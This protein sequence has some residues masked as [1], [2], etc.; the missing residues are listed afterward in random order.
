MMGLQSFKL[1]N[2]W[3]YIAYCLLV[4]LVNCHTRRGPHSLLLLLKSKNSIELVRHPF[5]DKFAKINSK[6][7]KIHDE[8][9]DGEFYERKTNF[10][11]RDRSVSDPG[12]LMRD[13]VFDSHKLLEKLIFANTL[14]RIILPY[15]LT[16]AKNGIRQFSEK[17]EHRENNTKVCLFVMASI[18]GWAY[19]TLIINYWSK[20]AS[21]REESVLHNICSK[22]YRV[23]MFIHFLQPTLMDYIGD[24]QYM[25]SEPVPKFTATSKYIMKVAHNLILKNILSLKTQRKLDSYIKKYRNDPTNRLNQRFCHLLQSFKHLRQLVLV[26]HNFDGNFGVTYVEN[27]DRINS[28][29]QKCNKLLAELCQ[30]KHEV[31]QGS[32]ADESKKDLTDTISWLVPELNVISKVYFHLLAYNKDFDRIAEDDDV[33]K[34][35]LA[36]FDETLQQVRNMLNKIG[37][38]WIPGINEPHYIWETARIIET[39]LKA[40]NVIVLYIL[41]KTNYYNFNDD[42][43]TI[44]CSVFPVLVKS[45][46]DTRPDLKGKFGRFS[47]LPSV[48]QSI[49]QV[50]SQKWNVKHLMKLYWAV[51]KENPAKEEINRRIK[52]LLKQLKKEETGKVIHDLKQLIPKSIRIMYVI[53]ILRYSPAV[54]NPF[55]EDFSTKFRVAMDVE[56]DL[57]EYVKNLCKN[58]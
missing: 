53:H 49:K 46:C 14:L 24:K 21:L 39:N 51:N 7:S 43:G 6:M 2:L 33:S 30:F 37:C 9:I 4:K 41:G 54:Y 3:K 15:P 42:C 29:V 12:Y 5:L 38:I 57:R 35:I 47:R 26:N 17:N 50:V 31:N 58:Q 18:Y 34:C 55:P 16:K 28:M 1:S 11:L 40:S 25:T 8:P 32:I 44:Y 48:D 52:E 13:C 36:K 19:Q 10:Y 23:V 22:V 45:I 27:P 20:E 56:I